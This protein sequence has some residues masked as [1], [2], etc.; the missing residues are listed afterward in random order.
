MLNIPEKVMILTKVPVSVDTRD[1]VDSCDVFK[2]CVNW[3]NF[4]GDVRIFHDADLYKW[5]E[6]KYTEPLITHNW[7]INKVDKSKYSL[8]YGSTPKLNTQN[9]EELYQSAGTMG[10]AMDLCVKY[11]AKKILLIADNTAHSLAF[12]NQVNDVLCRLSDYASFYQFSDGNF[13]C[14]VKS[15]EDFIAL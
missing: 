8:L 1:F 14:P 15:I 13:L 11:G 9:K 7:V 2:I 5:Y 3:C 12:R 6:E 4:K 10:K